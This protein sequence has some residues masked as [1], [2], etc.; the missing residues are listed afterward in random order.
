MG[1]MTNTEQLLRKRELAVF[2]ALGDGF[3]GVGEISDHTGY[4]PHSVRRSLAILVHKQFA[5]RRNYRNFELSLKGHSELNNMWITYVKQNLDDP[6]VSKIIASTIS[7]VSK[8]FTSDSHHNLEAS[9]SF[10]SSEQNDRFDPPYMHVNDHAC[11]DDA[12]SVQNRLA[13]SANSTNSLRNLQRDP[14][15]SSLADSAE[16]AGNPEDI[17]GNPAYSSRNPLEEELKDIGFDQP[18]R[19][20][21]KEDVS[22][23]LVSDWLEYVNGNGGIRNK[24]GF[25]RSQVE[26]GERPNLRNGRRYQVPAEYEGLIKR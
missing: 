7:E 22:W 6:E 26:A 20:L 4:S 12:D 11:M 5:V 1:L 8:M 18:G 13:D 23:E 9:K 3:S 2:L 15:R 21:Q 16:S 10:T 14:S 25:V 17:A 24:A 19:W